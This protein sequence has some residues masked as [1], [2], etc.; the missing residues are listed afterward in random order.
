[1]FFS[2]VFFDLRSLSLAVIFRLP[3]RSFC[4][5]GFAIASK[6]A[7]HDFEEWKTVLESFAGSETDAKAQVPEIAGE[8]SFRRLMIP[9]SPLPTESKQ[10]NKSTR[11]KAE[12]GWTPGNP[13]INREVKMLSLYRTRTKHVKR[14]LITREIKSKNCQK[15]NSRGLGSFSGSHFGFTVGRSN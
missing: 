7:K 5:V 8:N 11:A 15:G 12:V 10:E 1:M 3:M 6:S 2:N 9:L 14:Y 4:A 13:A